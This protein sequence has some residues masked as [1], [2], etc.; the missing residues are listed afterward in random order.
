MNI[1][2]KTA[3]KVL[4]VIVALSFVILK[5]ALI[6]GHIAKV[7]DHMTSDRQASAAGGFR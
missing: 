5:Y 7:V 3:G 4:L 2:I 6:A 1:K